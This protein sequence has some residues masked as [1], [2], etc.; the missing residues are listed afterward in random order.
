MVRSAMAELES[1]GGELERLRVLLES[2][3]EHTEQ[4]IRRFRPDLGAR[5]DGV[6]STLAALQAKAEET[7]F[8]RQHRKRQLAVL[9]AL[10]GAKAKARAAARRQ[11]AAM[12]CAHFQ[13]LRVELEALVEEEE[14]LLKWVAL[15]NEHSKDMPV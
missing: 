12:A 3:Q 8:G 2:S 4:D 14:L 6:R 11:D 1:A 7:D 5:L 15:F 13:Q 10:G 9:Q